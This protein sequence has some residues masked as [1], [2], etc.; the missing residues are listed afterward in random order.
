MSYD[1]ASFDVEFADGTSALVSGDARGA[2][3]AFYDAVADGIVNGEAAI[4]IT[5]NDSP[6]QVVAALRD[7]ATVDADRLAIVDATGEGEDGV[8]DG[9]TVHAVGSTGDLTGLSLAFAKQLQL[10]EDRQVADRVRVGLDTVST[11]LMYA[12]VQ[13]VFR[14]LHVFTSR[15]GSADLLGLF[16]LTPDM[17]DEKQVNTVRTL[18]DTE[19]RV[20]DG[21]ISLRGSGY[22]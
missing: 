1:T 12:E 3:T 19:A 8:V 6:E 15:L 17:H 13:T 16:T 7:R 18:F 9:V 10:L 5:T 4:V 2:R 21:E 11:L 20:T 22:D 14:F